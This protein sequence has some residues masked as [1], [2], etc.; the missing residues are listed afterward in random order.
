M[1]VFLQ[2]WDSRD[3]SIA[4]EGIDELNARGRHR[5][6][7]ADRLRRHRRARRA[8]F[9]KTTALEAVEDAAGEEFHVGL[10]G[11]AAAAFFST[12]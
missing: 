2:I 8:G 7:E 4:W 5:A 3:G 1:R 11:S 6:G 12:S 9:D 10:A